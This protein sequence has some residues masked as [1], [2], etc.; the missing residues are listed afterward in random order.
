MFKR[1]IAYMLDLSVISLSVSYIS[2]LFID[3]DKIISLDNNLS[4]LSES[5]LV[6]EIG[7]LEYINNSF[8]IFYEIDSLRLIFIVM[9]LSFS[10]IYFIFIPYFMKG[11]NNI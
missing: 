4:S 11:Q 5:F 8:K 9:A 3:N 7:F 1:L 6:E 10:I 2:S